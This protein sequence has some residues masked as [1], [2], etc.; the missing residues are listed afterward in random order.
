MPR[1]G[2]FA[3][4]HVCLRS[5]CEMHIAVHSLSHTHTY[6]YIYV[7][8]YICMYRSV[9]L[10]IHAYVSRHAYR[11]M[12]IH[13]IHMC[14]LIQVPFQSQGVMGLRFSGFES[15]RLRWL[16]RDSGLAVC[17]RQATLSP[18]DVPRSNM[19]IIASLLAPFLSHV[20]QQLLTKCCEVGAR[21]MHAK[22]A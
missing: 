3:R 18:L 4:M 21:Y 15:L 16:L 8:I 20:S 2:P 22:T 12:R 11:Y 14:W 6:T 1:S 17:R 10:Y 7:Y 19:G 5:F 9:C 13:F